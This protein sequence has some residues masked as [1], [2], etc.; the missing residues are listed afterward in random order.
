MRNNHVTKS[1]EPKLLKASII[2]ALIGGMLPLVALTYLYYD[3]N[4]G[5]R[6]E[7]S[8]VVG[9]FVFVK[10]FIA[11]LIFCVLVIPMIGL[12]LHRTNSLNRRS[13]WLTTFLGLVMLSIIQA[14]FYFFDY[15]GYGRMPPLEYFILS[16]IFIAI[17]CLPIGGLWF[18]LAMSDKL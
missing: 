17:F 18:K 1:I 15:L 14:I 10:H 7:P 3:F 2:S 12:I 9:L 5:V 16:F 13:F 11:V 8:E 4:Y 6:Y